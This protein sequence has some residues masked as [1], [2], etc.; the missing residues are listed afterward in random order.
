[1]GKVLLKYVKLKFKVKVVM[2]NILVPSERM[3]YNEYTCAKWKL[4]LTRILK[5]ASFC[6]RANADMNMDAGTS[7][8]LR[9]DKNDQV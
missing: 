4:C 7:V 8:M 3:G 2:S 6:S 1:M 5:Y 9:L